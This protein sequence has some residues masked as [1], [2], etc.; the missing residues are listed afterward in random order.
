M[1]RPLVFALATTAALVVIELATGAA[2]HLFAGGFALFSVVGALVIA[3]IAKALAAG[4]L[5][6]T[7][8]PEDLDG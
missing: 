7:G 3:G 8:R 2:T 5:Q 6:R 4:G 1:T